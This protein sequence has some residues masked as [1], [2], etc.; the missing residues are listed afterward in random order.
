MSTGGNEKYTTEKVQER[1]LE[2]MNEFDVFDDE[3][4]VISNATMAFT[5]DDLREALNQLVNS[6]NDKLKSLGT[7]LLAKWQSE[8]ASSPVLQTPGLPPLVNAPPPPD[9]RQKEAPKQLLSNL[10]QVNKDN[11]EYDD[12][13]DAIDELDELFQKHNTKESIQRKKTLIER[14]ADMQEMILQSMRPDSDYAKW[15]QGS[16]YAERV[17]SFGDKLRKALP[18]NEY[19]SFAIALRNIDVNKGVML[20]SLFDQDNFK[21]VRQLYTDNIQFLEEVNQAFVNR[22]ATQKKTAAQ[23]ISPTPIKNPN[24]PLPLIPEERRS[25]QQVLASSAH[26]SRIVIGNLL[27]HPDKNFI[28]DPAHEKTMNGNGG[29]SGAIKAM[30]EQ[31]GILKSYIKDIL[32]FPKV[33]GKRCPNGEVKHTFTGGIDVI[34]TSAPDLR[35]KQNRAT[36]SKTQPSNEAKQK[37]YQSYYNAFRMAYHLNAGAQS[38]NSSVKEPKAI[39][40]PILGSGIF[41][42][43]A[44]TSAEI[45]GKAAKDFR[46]KYGNALQINLYIRPQDLTAELTQTK[47][48]EAIDKGSK[49]VHFA[50]PLK[51]T[52]T[53]TASVPS[54]NQPQPQPS[55]SPVIDGVKEAKLRFIDGF[56]EKISKLNSSLNDKQARIRML[57]E[58]NRYVESNDV[59]IRSKAT[60]VLAAYNQQQERTQLAAPVVTLPRE[61]KVPNQYK[62]DFKL[63]EDMSSTLINNMVASEAFDNQTEVQKD[64]MLNVVKFLRPFV[65]K[66]LD[67]GKG[68]INLGQLMDFVESHAN[69]PDPKSFNPLQVLAD[70]ILEMAKILKITDRNELGNLQDVR[71]KI[72]DASKQ[73]NIPFSSN[74]IQLQQRASI[75]QESSGPSSSVVTSI[76]NVNVKQM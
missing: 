73:L 2:L 58:L 29:V 26:K 59:D 47:L 57:T 50:Q 28:V 25:T 71:E 40:C 55:V 74:V 6:S 3:F 66:V 44:E 19:H 23:T 18:P 53:S 65:D 39:N 64:A 75:P 36:G 49:G 51:A 52:S 17:A 9:P 60:E 4:T 72:I 14:L 67:F 54:I 70:G 10:A 37:L 20:K 11:I 16:D 34:H 42:W 41:K 30:Y 46:A 43:P 24:K 35:E 69:L 5:D 63:I 62:E 56:L 13:L 45:A 76:Q 22:T 27:D 61:L 38:A 48:Q 12:P 1:L 32:K 33:G 7:E 21:N 15:M 8:P 31:K 68:D